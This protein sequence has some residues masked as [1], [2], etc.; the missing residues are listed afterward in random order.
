M[1]KAKVETTKPRV[2]MFNLLSWGTV[3]RGYNALV[4]TLVIADYVNN[5]KASS[6]EY[7]P[8]IAIHAFEAL[9]PKSLKNYSVFANLYRGTEAGIAFFT[10]D[11]TMPRAA[12][13]ADVFI[14][15]MNL[16]ERLS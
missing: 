15:G 12:N 16:N 13:L 9:F 5:P 8:D 11:S 7:L 6:L 14:H 3:Y 4:A 1:A 2:S 10:G